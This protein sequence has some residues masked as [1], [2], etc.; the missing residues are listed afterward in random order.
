MWH[1]LTG[2]HDLSLEGLDVKDRYAVFFGKEEGEKSHPK[3]CEWL[4]PTRRSEGA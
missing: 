2:R 3:E 1:E 4:P